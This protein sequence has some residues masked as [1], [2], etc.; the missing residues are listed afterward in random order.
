LRTTVATALATLACVIPGLFLVVAWWLAMPAL[1]L[2][3]SPR[4]ALSRSYTLTNGHRWKLGLAFGVSLAPS[5]A[6]GLALFFL[7]KRLPSGSPLLLITFG[8]A[9]LRH[10]F[11]AP[12]Y[13]MATLAYL[14]LSGARLPT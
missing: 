7:N 10:A 4:Q 14:R 1:A 11:G 2:G 12:L 8:S 5:L 3:L 6:L 9:T 13:A